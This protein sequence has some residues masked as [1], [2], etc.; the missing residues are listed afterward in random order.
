MGSVQSEFET[1]FNERFKPF[2]C[3]QGLTAGAP[4]LLAPLR[5]PRARTAPLRERLAEKKSR[6]HRP[7]PRKSTR[8]LSSHRGAH[9]GRSD[10]LTRRL[11]TAPVRRARCILPAGRRAHPAH[12]EHTYATQHTLQTPHILCVTDTLF[13]VGHL[14][15]QSRFISCN[16]EC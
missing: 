11:P 14:C 16:K 3:R 10:A 15:L 8:M 2:L 9:S 7:A 5:I 13:T 1:R 6:N 12:S 4:R